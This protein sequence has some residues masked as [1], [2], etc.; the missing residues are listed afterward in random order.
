MDDNSNVHIV[1]DA[2]LSQFGHQSVL[3][4]KFFETLTLLWQHE[5]Q[6]IKDYTVDVV[7]LYAVN[8]SWKD[9]FYI[10]RTVEVHEMKRQFLELIGEK[11]KFLYML[12]KV[13][14]TELIQHVSN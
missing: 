10:C 12:G 11:L 3:K 8:D 1:P 4:L 5:L 13:D 14:I 6:S 9:L 2:D 7:F